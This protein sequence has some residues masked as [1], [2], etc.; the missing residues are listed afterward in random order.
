MAFSEGDLYVSGACSHWELKELGVERVVT[1]QERL[2]DFIHE[3]T[4]PIDQPLQILCED[5]VG[6]YLIPFLCRWRAGVWENAKTNRLVEA[7]VVGWREP[8]QR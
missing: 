2:A 6:T 7:T 8:D 5:H 3:G 1:R 4:P